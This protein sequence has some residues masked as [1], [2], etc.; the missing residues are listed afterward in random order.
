MMSANNKLPPKESGMFKKI[1][2][3]YE[4][5]QYKTGLKFAKQILSNPKFADHG[6]T[7]AMKGL[8]LN[9]MGRK[10]E[11]YDLV[12]KGLKNDLK[13]H[14]CW[15]VYGLLQRSEKKYDEAIKCYRNALKWDKENIQILRDLSLLQVQMRD[16]DGFRDTRYQL[17]KLRPAQRGSWIGYAVAY[18]MAKDY[19]TAIRIMGEYRATQ[20]VGQ[21]KPD[22]EYSEMIMYEAQLLKESGQLKEV[23]KFLDDHDSH[24]CDILAMQE[25]KAEVCIEL[26]NFND[27]RLLYWK[28]LK[29]NPE[30][31]FYYTSLQDL[32]KPA[33]PL[34][35]YVN[36]RKELPF[37]S[38]VKRLPLNIATGDAFAKL[39]DE[40]LQPGFHKGIPPL[41]V[42]LKS[43]YKDPTKV[44]II[45]RTVES[46]YHCLREHGSFHPPGS[47]YF[48][49]E[50]P[51][52]ELWVLFFLVR[53][54][55]TIGNTQKAMEYVDKAIEHTPTMMELCMIKAKVYKNAG[56]LKAAAHWMDEA[57]SLDTADR[58]VNSKFAKYLLRIDQ[59][60]EAVEK[61]QKFTREGASTLEILIEMQCMW[62]ELECALSYYRQ[63]KLGEAL[64]K[65]HQVEKHFVD[66][67]DDQFDFHTYC[68]RKMTL[69]AYINLIT[70]EDTL[71][72]HPFYV[73]V[74]K[75]AVKIY[76]QL[77]DN[78]HTEEVTASNE[79]EESAPSAEQK[80][81]RRKQRKAEL[82]AQAKLQEEKKENKPKPTDT[83]KKAVEEKEEEL[84]PAKLVA[85]KEPLEEALKFLVPLQ[86]LSRG[87]TDTHLMSYSIYSRKRKFLLMLRSL[88][89]GLLVNAEH[90]EMHIDVVDFVL[91][92]QSATDAELSGPV[93]QVIDEALP[94][95]L[96]GKSSVEEFNKDYLLRHQD[97]VPHLVTG[98]TVLYRLHPECRDEAI[99]LITN[100]NYPSR[101]LKTCLSVHSLLKSGALGKCPDQVA[102]FEAKCREFYPVATA[103]KPIHQEESTT[104]SP[105]KP[106]SL[107]NHLDS[108]ETDDKQADTTKNMDSLS[109]QETAKAVQCSSD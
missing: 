1:L 76:L 43:L 45:T 82:K 13:S 73:E 97:S 95:L 8:I 44:E 71:R 92:V 6:E 19:D 104:Q 23:L 55:T 72:D 94:T 90:P 52:A 108:H 87:C 34:Q 35:F 99:S 41:F 49:V 22:Y 65:C 27:A 68:M 20:S 48:A 70:L 3:S 102:S 109:S 60:D 86:H 4:C 33:D 46:F 10:E 7:Q 88:K 64:K 98:A 103:F 5:K 67:H 12:R 18:H 81:M 74:T 31:V 39:L 29:R 93:K 42:N 32:V 25:L 38:T 16:L 78:P 36:L 80:K 84:D 61:S 54:Y 79:K 50:P 106:A 40:Y 91:A 24:I 11:A 105:P 96:G 47:D 66:I 2:R 100:L 28:L 15:H 14:V 83:E 62:F 69:R 9:C 63:G 21:E 30:N 101:N 17:L 59:V 77:H 75:L 37:S 56:D 57:Q 107:E 58:Y 53:H 26:G 85:I 51:S 89:R